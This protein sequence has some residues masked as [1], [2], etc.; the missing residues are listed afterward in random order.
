MDVVYDT[1]GEIVSSYVVVNNMWKYT[2]IE[3]FQ[4]VQEAVNRYRFKI[5]SPNGFSRAKQLKE[6]FS[7]YF[8]SCAK[9]EVELVEEIPLLESGKRRMVVNK[10]RI[11]EGQETGGGGVG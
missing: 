4:F 3:Q 1:L 5:V 11:G 2:E 8:G 10:F 9:F 7:V 6:E